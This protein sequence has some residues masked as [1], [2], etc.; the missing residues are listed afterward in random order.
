MP[1]SPL[2]AGDKKKKRKEKDGR[3]NEKK[4]DEQ[5]LGRAGCR[6]LERVRAGA[7]LSA[8]DASIASSGSTQAGE[9]HTDTEG[10]TLR[11]G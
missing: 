1:R 2:H 9:W 4:Q 7:G 10:D 5:N 8:S 3:G 11:H 6:G